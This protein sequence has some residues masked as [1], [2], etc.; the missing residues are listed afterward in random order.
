[1]AKREKRR[2]PFPRRERLITI[3]SGRR[4][5][6]EAAEAIVFCDPERIVLRG[7]GFLEI[8]GDGLCLLELG[9]DNMAVEGRIRSVVFSEREP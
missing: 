7:G 6:M 4:L 8:R 3:Q 9:N 1:M 5:V 2:T